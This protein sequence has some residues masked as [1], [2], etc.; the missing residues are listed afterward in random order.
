MHIACWSQESQVMNLNA[1]V[2]KDEDG[3]VLIS[4]TTVIEEAHE[5]I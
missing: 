2:V 5:F 3:L 1:E 4:L